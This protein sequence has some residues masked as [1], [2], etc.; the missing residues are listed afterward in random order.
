IRSLISGSQGPLE[1]K[2][3]YVFECMF[4]DLGFDNDSNE[5]WKQAPFQ[6]RFFNAQQLVANL[7]DYMDKDSESYNEQNF[8]KGVEGEIKEQ[9]GDIF[10]NNII[11]QIDEIGTI[12]GFTASRTRKLL[13]YVTTYGEKKTV[14]LNLASRRIL[15]CLSPE[16][17][18]NEVDKII[19][20]RESEDGPFKVDTYSSLI[21]GQMV[22]DSTWNDISSIVSVGPSSSASAY[23]SILSKVDYG[24][25]TYFM[26][27]VVYR[28]SS[29]DL[30]EIA[31]V[32]IF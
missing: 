30:P 24:T 5:V 3:R 19:E 8:E 6:G 15:K 12:P 20:Y 4:R 14:N 17:L 22:A 21:R 16:I 28:W 18:P 27:A 32:E 7:I 31:S 1:A 25:A 11:Q 13:P 23:F 26:R 10:K 2:W 9:D 29:G